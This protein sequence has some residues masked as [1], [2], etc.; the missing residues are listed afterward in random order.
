MVADRCPDFREGGHSV[1]RIHEKSE[2]KQQPG[3]G[4]DSGPDTAVEGLPEAGDSTVFEKKH[5]QF[6]KK[7]VSSTAINVPPNRASS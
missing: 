3:N 5:S 2:P 6:R 4:D 1:P 7:R